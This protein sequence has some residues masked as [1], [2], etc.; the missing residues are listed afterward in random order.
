ME[1]GLPAAEG[2]TPFSRST[3]SADARRPKAVFDR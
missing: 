3:T 1:G 2:T